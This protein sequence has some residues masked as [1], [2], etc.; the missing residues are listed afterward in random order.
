MHFF[1]GSP[2]VLAFGL[3]E[4]N[5]SVCVANLKCVL[6]LRICIRHFARPGVLR[7]QVSFFLEDGF[8]SQAQ[9]AAS[10]REQ[11]DSR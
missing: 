10:R 4:Q 7:N 9:C 6:P 3:T 5:S 8:I 2:I 1:D 11:P